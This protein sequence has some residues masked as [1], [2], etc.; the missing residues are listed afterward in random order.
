MGIRSQKFNPF[1]PHHAG[2]LGSS[3]LGALRGGDAPDSRHPAFKPSGPAAG[4]G[5][6]RS[7]PPSSHTDQ[8]QA[9]LAEGDSA[10]G[11]GRGRGRSR[12]RSSRGEQP[13]DM[14]AEGSPV[15]PSLAN[16]SEGAGRG[17][18]VRQRKFGP[19]C[20]AKERRLG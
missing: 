13:Q 15:D 20:L 18:R 10:E 6:G 11:S 5:R 16:A 7:R 17:R 1:D 14:L 2:T 19:D 4:G 12:S 8:P 9:L 3:H